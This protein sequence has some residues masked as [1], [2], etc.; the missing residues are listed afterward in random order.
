MHQGPG[1]RTEDSISKAPIHFLDGGAPATVH[2]PARYRDIVTRIYGNVGLE[3]TV[4]SDPGRP[5]ADLPPESSYR[6][7]TPKALTVKIEP[8]GVTMLPFAIYYRTYNDPTYNAFFA[9]PM[10]I[11]HRA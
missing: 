10:E 4:E 2:V 8:S 7:V 11:E 5:P 9:K 6:S 3:R 1:C